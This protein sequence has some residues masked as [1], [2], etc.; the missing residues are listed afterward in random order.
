MTS[1]HF[2]GRGLVHCDLPVHRLNMHTYRVSVSRNGEH[3]GIP[4]IL[5][6]FDGYCIDCA[7]NGCIIKVCVSVLVTS[8]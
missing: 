4:G 7:G 3:Y 8:Y 1:G 5:T 2:E 6:V